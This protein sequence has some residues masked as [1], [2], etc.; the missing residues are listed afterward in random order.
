MI[1][2]APPTLTNAEAAPLP[3]TITYVTF[4]SRTATAPSEHAE[5][6]DTLAD[7][8]TRHARRPGKDGPG[9]SPAT[10]RSRPGPTTPSR[11]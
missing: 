11:R 3:A 7:R 10:Y 6:W 9:W 2:S 5:T 4:P 1:A 8:L